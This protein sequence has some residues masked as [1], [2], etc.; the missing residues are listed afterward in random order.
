MKPWNASDASLYNA[1]RGISAVD[2]AG[3]RAEEGEA[4]CRAYA[5]PEVNIGTLRVDRPTRKRGGLLPEEI[6]AKEAGEG[7]DPL[8]AAG[9][10]AALAGVSGSAYA[11]ETT[12]RE[13]LRADRASSKRKEGFA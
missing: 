6:S 12:E 7:N 2:F 10:S 13:A 1:R 3:L 5:V 9:E 8:C 11:T 4:C